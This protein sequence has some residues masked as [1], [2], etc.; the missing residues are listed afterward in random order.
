MVPPAVG[1][2]KVA[3]G[4]AG[5]H[6]QAPV[7]G[8]TVELLLVAMLLTAAFDGLLAPVAQFDRRMLVG[9]EYAVIGSLKPPEL[10]RGEHIGSGR[11]AFI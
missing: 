9:A 4:Q 7:A 5:G 1:A 6:L 8:Y 10:G 2:A 11:E 3:E